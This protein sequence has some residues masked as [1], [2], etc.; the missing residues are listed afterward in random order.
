MWKYTA[1]AEKKFSSFFV[2]DFAVNGLR[3]DVRKINTWFDEI[4]NADE[5]ELAA[6]E[7]YKTVPFL[8]VSEGLSL[9][10]ALAEQK[11]TERDIAIA[12]NEKE[13]SMPCYGNQIPIR[14]GDKKVIVEEVEV[15]LKEIPYKP[16]T[17]K[18]KEVPTD[19]PKVEENTLD[20]I[21]NKKT[22]LAMIASLEKRIKELEHKM[23]ITWHKDC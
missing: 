12:F 20:F 6:N 2:N 19:T 18:S 17:V 5:G 16:E 11:I 13:Y 4:V 15:K 21:P 10:N 1:E 7:C 3:F 8:V 23:D 14:H 22:L 9:A